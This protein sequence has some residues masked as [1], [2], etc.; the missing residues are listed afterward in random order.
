ML[1][2][3]KFQH[4]EHFW[5]INKNLIF[6]RVSSLSTA[7][8]PY[9]TDEFFKDIFFTQLAVIKEDELLSI[10]TI[11]NPLKIFLTKAFKLHLEL[12]VS[13]LTNPRIDNHHTLQQIKELDYLTSNL[14]IPN[15]TQKNA[16][17]KIELSALISPRRRTRR[18]RR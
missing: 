12:Q 16:A 14:I 2:L 7:K 15:V 6:F 18:S 11:I 5:H 9:V 4:L 13:R 8:R 17:N 1:N 10:S 3:D